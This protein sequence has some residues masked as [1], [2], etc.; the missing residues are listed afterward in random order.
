MWFEVGKGFVVNLGYI[1]SC[2]FFW[3]I[4]FSRFR[5]IGGISGMEFMI[6]L[7]GVLK[8]GVII[9]SKELYIF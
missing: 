1:R 3:V 7:N 8:K 4:L 9:W 6:S 5:V 2:F